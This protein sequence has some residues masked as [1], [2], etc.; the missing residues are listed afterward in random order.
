M[1]G[2]FQM[3]RRESDKYLGQHLHQD[4][5]GAS[6]AA[7]VTSRAGKFKGA[8]FE[9]KSVV[10]EFS[11]AV[12]GPMVAAK[13]LLE[14]ALLPSLLY[15]CG[16][17]IQMRKSTEEECDNLICLFWRAM[18]AVPEGTPKIALF[19]E[20]GTMRTKWR[21]WTEKIMMVMK[22]QQQKPTSLARMV[23]EE[24][25]R[26]AWPGLSAE[27][28][29]ICDKV[30]VKDVNH[31]I[32]KKEDI[33]EAVFWNHYVDMKEEMDKF[34]KLEKI[35]H[36]DFRTEQEYM[37]DKSIEKIRSQFRIRTKLV[38]MFKDN[39]RNKHRTLPRGEE[40]EDQG[41]LCGD[42]E[43]S[44]DTQAHCLVC[45]AWELAREGLNFTF[46]EDMVLYF[47]R[48]LEGREE[49]REEERVR[50]RKEREEEA[51]GREEQRRGVKR[52]RG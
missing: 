26:L 16:N 10:E 6:V 1:F 34:S 28:T 13:T 39:F 38:A 20:T 24:Q 33:K 3:T 23:Y 44:R 40:D 8:V 21:V 12:M 36:E 49:R 5:A 15:G 51:R 2:E 30:K 17:W 22:I 7:T 37:K 4:G 11:M 14:R 19:A 48:V 46:V 45:P 25:L 31:N 35:K 29:D 27:V 52:M 42:C 47:R 50:R 43:G 9:V 41:L 32:V 18:L